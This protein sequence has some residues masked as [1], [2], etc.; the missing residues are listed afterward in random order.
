MDLTPEQQ[1]EVE[2]STMS[3]EQIY[4]LAKRQAIQLQRYLV[5][6]DKLRRELAD[7]REEIARMEDMLDKR[8]IEPR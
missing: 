2:A 7:A 6:L 8:G 1:F 5:G 4:N 3:R